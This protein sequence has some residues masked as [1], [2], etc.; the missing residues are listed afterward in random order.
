MYGTASVVEV[1]TTSEVRRTIAHKDETGKWSTETTW[2]HPKSRLIYAD[3]SSNGCSLKLAHGPTI[4][5]DCVDKVN[6]FFKTP[7]DKR[8]QSHQDSPHLCHRYMTDA[9]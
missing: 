1:P 5:R 6:E 7:L 8:Y 2:L 9:N 4:P 3:H